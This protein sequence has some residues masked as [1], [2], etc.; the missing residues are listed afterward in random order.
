MNATDKLVE[1]RY[2]LKQMENNI[3]DL[4]L[5]KYNLS[6][7]LSASRSVT[8][9]LQKEFSG[10]K[11]FELWYD[12]KQLQMSKDPLFVFFKDTRNFV[13][14][15]CEASIIGH[16]KASFS[17]NIG[18]TDKVEL[19]VKRGNGKT[20]EKIEVSNSSSNDK[21]QEKE[22]SIDRRW[23][24]IDYFGKEQEVIPLCHEYVKG[25]EDLLEEAHKNI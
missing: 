7:F 4:K 17:L 21:K 13:V 9:H 14:K 24:F 15:E 3:D 6:A 12:I 20:I 1:T 22:S 25:L 23:F 2:F 11:N 8:W 18:L 10:N 16:H 5:F 19:E